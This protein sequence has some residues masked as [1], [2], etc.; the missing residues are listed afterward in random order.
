MAAHSP[1]HRVEQATVAGVGGDVG[2]GGAD[3][4]RVFVELVPGGR[5]FADAGL[6]E[7]V[8][9]VEVGHGARVGGH[10]VQAAVD[11]HG[12]P[13]AGGECVLELG[14]VVDLAQVHERVR[15]HELRDGEVFDQGDVRQTAAGLGR[16]VECGVGL[17]GLA[18]VA[19]LHRDVRIGLHEGFGGAIDA[20]VPRPY[21][22]FGLARAC[23][24]VAA[25]RERDEQGSDGSR[26][27][28]CARGVV[29][30]GLLS[31]LDRLWP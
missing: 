9:V 10:R 7:H 12:V 20:G 26:G 23:G 15:M 19:H 6:V 14:G 11:V 28:D 13:C 16:V 24:R 22:Q 18:D 31:V 3:L 8:L 27:Y 2:A 30:V 4:L 25:S 17:V 29:H 5:W 1:H 21:R